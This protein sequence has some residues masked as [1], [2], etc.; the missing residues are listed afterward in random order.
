M[1]KLAAVILAAGKGNRMNLGDINKVTLLVLGKPIIIHNFTSLKNIGI[2][3]I[4]IVVGHAKQSVTKL[5]KD[6]VF[7]E[8][9]AQK[10]T[11]DAA[12][13]ALNQLPKETMH[14]L[15]INGD[16]L[17]SPSLLKKFIKEY[18][19]KMPDLLFA[20]AQL[21]NPKGIGRIVRINGKVSKIVEEKDASE[22]ERSIKEVNAGCYIGRVSFFKKYLAK[23]SKSLITGEY[24]LTDT[25]D[26]ALKNNEKIETIKWGKIP[27][28]AV[29]T[30][31]DLIKIQ[32]EIFFDIA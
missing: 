20:T 31:Q 32:N 3:P 22:K 23:V 2:D 28:M 19:L 14:S 15:I 4:I 7:V 24:Y 11:A 18:F 8:Q 16:T 26:L 29:N 1:N 9:K 27:W 10:G 6:A 17:Y 21:N 30:P 25:I 12:M 5:F 13:Q